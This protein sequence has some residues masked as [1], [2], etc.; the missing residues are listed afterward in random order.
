MCYKWKV[1]DTV[2]TNFEEQMKKI[3]KT[4]FENLKSYSNNNK[5]EEFI[6][7]DFLENFKLEKYV[8]QWINKEGFH[9]FHEDT[10]ESYFRKV[11]SNNWDF[12]VDW[13]IN[14][15]GNQHFAVTINMPLEFEYNGK[16]VSD[17]NDY[18]LESYVEIRNKIINHLLFY[19]KTI[20]YI[21]IVPEKNKKGVLHFHILISIRNFI[22]YNYTL[23]NNLL[24][25][26]KKL[27][28]IDGI[29]VND[30]DIKVSSLMYFKDVKNWAIYMYKD[31][32]NWRF[33]SNIYILSKYY[34]SILMKYLGDITFH[35]L[36]INCEF[37]IIENNYNNI[38]NDL[39]GIK[40]TNNKIEQTTLI[41]LL[42]YY[43]ILNQYYVYNDTVYVKIKN[44]K[45]S[46]KLVGNL[47]E[48]LY[49]KFQENVVN[50]FFNNFT[51]YFKG[52]DFNYL[53]NNYFIKTKNIIES[54]RD[55]STERI[56]PD[57]G[58]IEFSDGIYSIKYDRFFSN[59]V[60]YIF[61]NKIATLKY[62]NK[63]YGWIR[64]HK[65]KI[66]ISG[67]KNALNI[68]NNEF[69]NDDYV[70]LCLHMINPIHK[71]LFNKKSSLF[72]YGPSNTGK[73]SFV[74]NVMSGYYTEENIGSTISGKNFKWQHFE[75][76]SVGLIDEA[77]Y[78]KS[79]VSDWLKIIG[80]EKLIVEKKYSKNH[81]S[82][83]PIPLI[84]VSNMLFEDTNKDVD[85]ALKNRLHIIE[86]INIISNDNLNCSRIFKKKLKE[87]EPNIIIYC[88]KLLFKLK[89]PNLKMVGNK[90]SNKEILKM[91]EY[92]K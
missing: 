77:R 71:N 16:H 56:E 72:I 66:W 5:N 29:Y 1:S 30:F 92:K 38:I 21:F 8:T 58:L 13:S 73:T 3:D 9:Y 83:N 55:I 25:C 57:F 70:K 27:T 17:Y 76:K 20:T 45:I 42:Q 80:G 40:L 82:I 46:Y 14:I 32:Y 36:Q 6:D 24:L 61:N 59:K 91:L 12:I 69:T 18:N 44:S 49:N 52:F 85:E 43:L 28:L 68:K 50:Y 35:F 67:I 48:I 34:D 62:Y 37:N 86:F 39:F 26:L 74:I 89:D 88:N 41:S 87:E 90:I 15:I 19:F 7:I 47:T 65:P 81:I 11:L 22:D 75:G 51:Y 60:G 84:I 10:K 53:L 2:N 63:S 23:K 79:T 64:Q 78:T 31:M 33:P 4:K 54:I